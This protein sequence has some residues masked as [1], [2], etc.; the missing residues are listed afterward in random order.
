MN[1]NTLIAVVCNCLQFV[2]LRC[3]QNSKGEKDFGK[4]C[5]TEVQAFE[6]KSAQDYRFNFRLGKQCKKDIERLC[7]D[8]CHQDQGQVQLQGTGRVSM[9]TALPAEG[10]MAIRLLPSDYRRDVCNTD[11]QLMH[12]QPLPSC[13]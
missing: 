13:C 8:V 2:V 12:Q 7:K 10:C 9:L 6:Q 4:A 5:L 3:L 11:R 1:Q